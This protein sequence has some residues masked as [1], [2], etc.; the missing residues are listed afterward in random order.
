MIDPS[1]SL[2]D[3]PPFPFCSKKCAYVDLGVWLRGEYVL[4]GTP[5][6]GTEEETY[7][8]EEGG[9]SEGYPPEDLEE[10]DF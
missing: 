5:L 6:S 8:L 10:E 3:P 7:L 9:D 2:Q 1:S 4:P